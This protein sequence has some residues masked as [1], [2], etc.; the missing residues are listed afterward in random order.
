RFILE[1]GY[2]RQKTVSTT[3]KTVEVSATEPEGTE[4][5]M[6]QNRWVAS[7]SHSGE[8]GVADS[9]SYLQYEDAEHVEGK[10]RIKN[11]VGQ[12]IWTVPLPANVLS[13]GLFYRHEDLTDLTGNGLSGATR[14]GATRT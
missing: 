4:A 11:T 10:K 7:L 9:D 1:G 6:T 8:W 3:G 2:Y 14:T 12:S 5:P 13:V